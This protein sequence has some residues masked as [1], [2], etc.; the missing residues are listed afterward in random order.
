MLLTTLFATKTREVQLVQI[1]YTV[2]FLLRADFSLFYDSPI[3]ENKHD[4]TKC[5][6]KSRSTKQIILKGLPDVEGLFL[7]A[8]SVLIKTATSG[9]TIGISTTRL[10]LPSVATNLALLTTVT[11]SPKIMVSDLVK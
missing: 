2:F 3:K 5:T 9:K 10:S 7:A 8:G 4:N 11:F 6:K 1:K